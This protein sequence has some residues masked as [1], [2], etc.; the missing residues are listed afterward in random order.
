MDDIDEEETILD[1]EVLHPYHHDSPHKVDPSPLE[2]EVFFN[3]ALYI[4]AIKP[5]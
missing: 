5:N 3:S 4:L 1:E 2:C